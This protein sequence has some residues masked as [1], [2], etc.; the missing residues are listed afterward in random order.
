LGC[1]CIVNHPVYWTQVM[2]WILFRFVWNTFIS[3]LTDLCWAL[4]CNKIISYYEQITF[5][6]SIIYSGHEQVYIET[7]KRGNYIIN[8]KKDL[9]LNNNI[10]NHSISHSNAVCA[11]QL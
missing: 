4:S 11:V 7:L 8:I 1:A 3:Y 9:L 2:I 5:D 6:K 10:I